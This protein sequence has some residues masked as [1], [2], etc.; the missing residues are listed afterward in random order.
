MLPAMRHYFTTTSLFLALLAVVGSPQTLTA[1]GPGALHGRV[2]S[3]QGI[4]VAGALVR[5]FPMGSEVAVRGADTDDLGFYHMEPLA[6]G[7]YLMEVGRLGFETKTREVEVLPDRRVE[8]D[9][10]L[11]TRALAVEGISVEAERSRDRV[12]FEEEAGVTVR[13]LAGTEIKAIPGL[14]EADPL[15]AVEVLPGVVTTSDFSSAFNVRGGSAD[16]NL[17]LLDGQPVFNPTHL[18]GFF[19][20]FNAD[21]IERAEL[22]SGGFPARFGGRVSSVLDIH[23]DPGD[24]QLN[25]DAGISLLATRLAVGAGLPESLEEKAGLRDARWRV[26][27][28]RSYFDQVLKAAFDFP[29]HLTDLQ[30]VFE[31]WT[32]GGDRVA[33]TAYTGRDVLELTRLDPE[34]F[35]LRIDWKWGNDLVGLSFTNPRRDGGWLELRTGYSRFSSG[36]SFPDFDD[37]EFVSEISQASA[38]ADLE[39][40]P[41][42]YATMTTGAGVKRLSENNLVSTGGTEFFSGEGDGTELSGYLQGVWKPSRDWL[43]E[44]GLRA[45]RWSPTTGDPVFLLSPRFSAKRFLAGSQWA[46]KTSGGRYG[47]FLH[48]IRDEE[49]PLGLDTWILSG[50]KAPHVVSDQVQIGIEGYPLEGWFT[51]LEGYYRSFDGVVTLNFADNPND[52]GDDYLPGRG[53]SYGA[54]LF[55][56][57]SQG[58][59]TGWL[60]VSWLRATRTFPDFQ[61]GLD[62]APEVTYPPIFDRR[63]DVDLVLQRD[64][65]RGLELGLR[66]NFGTGLPFTRPLGSYAYLSPSTIPGVGLEWER[67]DPKED[68]E[69]AEGLYGVVL[70][71]RNEAR[72]PARHRLDVSLRWVLEKSWGRMTPYLS[73]LNVY[74]RKNV[75]FYFFEYAET[76]PVRTGI[77]MFPI[78]PTIGME[79]SF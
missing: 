15:R 56:R 18:G 57:R 38:E 4:P 46:V 60:A 49:L 75:L 77:S 10:T 13:E 69:D 79:V 30:G 1:Q 23:S 52:D 47:Q 32:R 55:I 17:I 54:D 2:W 19:S 20:V 16:Q 31:G 76:P 68:G 61:S 33:L 72:Y 3:D 27:G 22:Q 14:V 36:L 44:V 8:A 34:D 67:F 70:L 59:T 43:V 28:R 24:G 35:P 50:E 41:T 26:S 63:L 74:N 58:A 53:T 66:W 78:L 9:L 6:P 7:R 12:R 5:L 48:S 71:D 37:T 45:D 25:V 65:R 64:L 21:M 11:V 42:P 51:S 73:V 62:P 39:I 40:R 29:Y